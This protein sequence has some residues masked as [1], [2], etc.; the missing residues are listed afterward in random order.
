[1]ETVCVGAVRVDQR[2]WGEVAGGC[3]WNAMAREG[4]GSEVFRQEGKSRET[5]ARCHR[6]C[7]DVCACHPGSG[8]VGPPC[9]VP[10]G[11]GCRVR[12]L[13]CEKI[14]PPEG[15]R[16]ADGGSSWRRQ[17][18]QPDCRGNGAGA[19]NTS[20]VFPWWKVLRLEETLCVT[21][22]CVQQWGGFKS[23]LAAADCTVW[24]TTVYCILQQC[25]S[26]TGLQLARVWG[27]FWQKSQQI[28]F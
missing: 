21:S 10:P 27:D 20:E 4:G 12:T 28:F 25:F 17:Q 19:R 22:A 3:P 6:V 9:V 5:C 1:M 7:W 16:D 11:E 8:A 13:L 14:N 2:C 18:L 23:H 15:G 26:T 24:S